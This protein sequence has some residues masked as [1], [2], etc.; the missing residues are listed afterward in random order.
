MSG[1]LGFVKTALG[2]DKAVFIILMLLVALFLVA[3]YKTSDSGGI[4]GDHDGVDLSSS[5][6]KVRVF[7]E[8]AL[9]VASGLFILLLIIYFL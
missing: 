5:W 3:W 7:S 6:Y 4:F 9:G 1:V 2:L 8:K